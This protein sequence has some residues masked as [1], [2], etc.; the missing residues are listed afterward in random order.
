MDKQATI[1]FILIALVV[2]IWMWLNTPPPPQ[3]RPQPVDT[4]LIQATHQDTARENVLKKQASKTAEDTLGAFFAPLAVGSEKIFIVQTD[5]YTAQL[6]TKGGLI[7]EWKLEKFKTWDV[8]P[9]QLVEYDKGGDFSLLFTSA[10]GKLIDTHNLYFTGNFNPWQRITLMGDE[11]YKVDFVL[12]INDT[13][14][15][16]K[17]FVFRNGKYSFDAIIQLKKMQNIISNFEYEVVW[18]NGLHL[19]EQNSIDEASF[20][21]AYAYIGEELA[22]VD[23]QAVGQEYKTNL[24]GKT[25][26]VATRNKYFSV[27]IIP[28][29]KKGEGAYLSGER[30]PLP[31]KGVKEDYS[32]ALK[33]PYKEE[34]LEEGRF[35]VFLGPLDFDLVKS[36]KVNL[37]KMMSFG[38]EWIIRP[39]SIYFMLPLFKLLHRFIPNY[40]FVIIVFSVIIRILLYPL[41]LTSMKSMKKMQ[42]L[43]PMMEELR[44]KYKEDPQRLNKEIMKLYKEYGVNPASGC[45][46]MLPQLPILY[47]LWAVFRATIELRQAGFIWWIKDLSIPDTIVHLPF[48]IP[49]FGIT[50]ISGLALFMGVTMLIQQKMTVKD[51]RQKTMVWLLPL[52]LTLAFNGLPSGLNLYYST[53]NVLAIAQQAWTNK[54]GIA[55]VQL[56]K[57][58]QKRTAGGIF[59]RMNLPSLKRK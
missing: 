17:T 55:D 5:L 57:V 27:A 14:R 34:P 1:G 8:N 18:E 3:R 25:D 58:E 39:I 4:T 11:E 51:P 24:T 44:V 46:P 48:V 52:L 49:F 10:D 20:A 15:I 26:W 42:A 35:A 56:K 22:E 59:N 45:L 12:N 21:A 54:K 40:G 29:G 2:L 23:A 9:V 37:E 38:L 47:A 16:I 13:S 43:Q 7:K 19:T 28:V 33:M 31:N 50:Q 53:F 32:I 41:T 6:T 36:Y 30:H